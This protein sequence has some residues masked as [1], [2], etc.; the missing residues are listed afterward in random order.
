MRG[1]GDRS[2]GATALLGMDGF[3]VLSQMETDGKIWLLVETTVDLVGC[4]DCG[5][6]AVG[7]GRSEVQVRDLPVGGRSVRLVWR[8]RRWR[9]VDPDCEG[10]SF[11]ETSELVEGCLTTGA[12]REVCR[13]VGE[14]GRSVASV[15]LSFG[16][17]W[18]RA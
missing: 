5:V 7:H 14:D 3:V 10:G 9:F 6:R 15:A 12:G 13:L 11:T 17:S 2:G 8:K 4:P 16:I 1:M 18:H